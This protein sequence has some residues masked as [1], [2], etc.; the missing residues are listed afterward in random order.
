LSRE[1]GSRSRS[2]SPVEKGNVNSNGVVNNG[3]RSHSESSPRSSPPQSP[4]RH[5]KSGDESRSRSGSPIDD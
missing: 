4:R 2:R 1:V 5:R 3:K